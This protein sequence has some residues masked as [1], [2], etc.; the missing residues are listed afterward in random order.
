MSGCG[1]RYDRKGNVF[2]ESLALHY[3]CRPLEM[4][5]V[6]LKNFFELYE[7]LCCGKGEKN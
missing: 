4:E 2:L 7:V 1:V 5:N 6:C 3:L